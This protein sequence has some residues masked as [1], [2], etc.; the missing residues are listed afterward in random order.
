MLWKWFGVAYK[1][2]DT[3]TEPKM[4]NECKRRI[5]ADLLDGFGT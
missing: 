5:K 4:K 3:A 2:I 1:N